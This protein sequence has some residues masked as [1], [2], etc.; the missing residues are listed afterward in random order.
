MNAGIAEVRQP[1]AELFRNAAPDDTVLLYYT[2]HGLRDSHGDLHFALPQTDVG[3]L[4]VNSLEA[5]FVLTQMNRSR[6][7]R[8]ILILDCCYSAAFM[9]T[10][11]AG[12]AEEKAKRGESADLKKTDFI[13]AGG[14]GRYVL[15]AASANE[16]ACERGGRTIY[17]HYLVEG[18]REGSA[19]PEN[20]NTTVQDLHTHVCR[21]I[22]S[23]EAS[24]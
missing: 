6:S 21:M 4:E 2:V 23:D 12:S 10:H 14:Q 15:A 11:I 9:V 24:K 3:V 1:I 5:S 20:D 17:T 13:E 7:Q 18:L 16:S 19:A 8:Q 22:S